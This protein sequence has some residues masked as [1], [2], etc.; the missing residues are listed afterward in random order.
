MQLYIYIHTVRSVGCGCC[1]AT[2]GAAHHGEEAPYWRHDSDEGQGGPA[3]DEGGVA[4]LV[5]VAL[6]LEGYRDEDGHYRYRRDGRGCM[7]RRR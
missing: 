6:L 4:F 5:A 1:N 7:Q 2:E 3:Q